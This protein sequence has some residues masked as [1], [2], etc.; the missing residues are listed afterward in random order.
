MRGRFLKQVLCLALSAGLALLIV[1]AGRAVAAPTADQQ[2]PTIDPLRESVIGGSSD[3][4][5]AQIIK[6]G[7][8]GVLTEIRLPVSCNPSDTLQVE[9][10]IA[11][12]RTFPLRP[13][14][15]L[16]ASESIPGS[17][18]PHPAPGLR[19]IPLASPPFLARDEEFA[20]VLRATSA[21]R[22]VA[23]PG[24]RGDSYT[25]GHAYASFLPN[26]LENWYCIC[27][28]S[29]DFFYDLA[30]QTLVDPM[31]GVPPVEGTELGAAQET[32][33]THGCSTGRI[34]RRYS[35]TV[36][37]GSVISQAPP[38]ETR[39]ASGSPVNLVVSRGIAYCMVPN[40]RGR[41]L[42]AATA[43]LQRNYCRRGRVR[44][45][46]SAKVAMGRI[47]SQAPRPGVRLASGGRVSLV[48]SQGRAG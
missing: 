22:C 24:P 14:G 47:I 34:E 12:S 46:P 28:P 30:F 13:I 18:I 15:G 36:P 9:I 6:A 25:R 4:R 40:V 1:G 5:L 19:S 23:R 16:L 38:P 39:L 45:R 48:V 41:S 26:S 7:V 31:C 2:Q 32:I 29:R 43:V 3:Q 8:P 11:D 37:A 44:R 42:R 17:R 33:S 10:R 20:V 21:A 27:D 35:P